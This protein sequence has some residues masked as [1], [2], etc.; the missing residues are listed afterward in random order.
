MWHALLGDEG[1]IN[2]GTKKQEHNLQFSRMH[3]N[4]IIIIMIICLSNTK[5]IFMKCVY[6]SYRKNETAIDLLQLKTIQYF[7]K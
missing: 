5:S 6:V 4:P 3:Y 7:E 1:R 2:T